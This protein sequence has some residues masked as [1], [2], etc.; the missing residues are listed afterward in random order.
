[1]QKIGVLVFVALY[2]LGAYPLFAAE[3]LFILGEPITAQSALGRHASAPLAAVLGDRTTQAVNQLILH[4]DALTEST[5]EIALPL[6][7]GLV[8]TASRFQT[9][10]TNDGM[11]TWH[12]RLPDM[13]TKNRRSAG[14]RQEAPVDELNAVTLVRHGDNIW[15]SIRY[16]GQFYQVTPLGGGEHVIVK[17]DETK[18]PDDLV[19]PG[20]Q[21]GAVQTIAQPSQALSIIRV[22]LIF[23]KQASE[24]W[25]DTQG[26]GAL[27]FAEANQGVRNSSVRVHFENAGVFPI[28]YSDQSG[29]DGY[30]K[31]LNE[32]EN[33]TEASLGAPVAKLRDQHKADLVVLVSKASG[34][35][36]LA[37][38]NSSKATAF[39]VISCPTGNFTFA[40]EMGHNFGLSHNSDVPGG[41]YGDG[42]GYQQNLKSPYWRTIMS[43]DCT[44]IACPRVNYWSD[45]DRTYDGLQMGIAG[46]NNSVRVIN[47][48]REVLANFYPP[49]NDEPPSVQLDVPLDV[50]ANQTFIARAIASDPMGNPLTYKW[51]APGFAPGDGTSDSLALKAPAVSQDEQKTLSVEVSNPYGT[52]RQSK[53]ITVMAPDAPISAQMNIPATVA[54]G[55]QLPVSVEA[56]SA[57]GLPLTYAWSRTGGMYTGTTGGK[58]NGVYTAVNVDKDT[59]TRIDV[60]VS[61]RTHQVSLSSPVI[62]LAAPVIAEPVARISGATTAEAATPVALSGSGSSGN[63]LIY[64][65]TAAGFTPASSTLPDP[66]FIAPASTGNRNITLLVTDSLGLTASASHQ[67]EVIQPPSNTCAPPWIASKAYAVIN[68]KVSYDGYNYEVA[69]WT[70]NNR[71]DLNW[72]PSGDAKPWRRLDTC[73][74]R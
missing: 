49:V 13:R 55:G 24:A 36:G 2:L 26:L 31:M 62:I 8:V 5:Q 34:Y 68:E 73:S 37:N 66:T 65:W 42:Y 51:S 30:K 56:Y 54:S 29:A 33:P 40:H 25:P 20:D 63:Q 32:L 11:L 12:G 10:L 70:Q 21:S 47:L 23:T 3:E 35:C 14:N 53:T 39:G 19:V 6:E 59:N 44:P 52:T 7:Q 64:A 72:A 27:M 9:E 1:M 46:I 38:V 18:Y 17:V 4:A 43:Y 22:M 71:P 16:R 67:I 69:H 45:P 61:D 58:P 60:V 15:G 41:I 48:R 50:A 74:A 57:T 28:N